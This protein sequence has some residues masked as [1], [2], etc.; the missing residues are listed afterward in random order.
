MSVTTMIGLRYYRARSTNGYI[1]LVTMVSF[2]GL[3]LGVMALVVVVSVMNGFDRELKQRILGAVPHVTVSEISTRELE[4]ELTGFSVREITPFQESQLLILTGSGSH[5][6]TVYG[7]NP[8]TEKDASILG[9]SMVIGE[10]KDLQGPAL[11]LILGQSIARRFGL[12]IGQNISLVVPVVSSRG[13]TVKPRLFRA[14]LA[15]TFAMGSELDHRLGVMHLPDLHRIAGQHSVMR[16]TLDDIFL[17]PRVEEQLRGSGYPV[18]SWTESFGDFFR[19]VRMEKIMMF[20]LLSFVVTIASFSIVS[21]VTMMV[22]S[23]K[24]DIAVL[25]TMGLSEWG[26]FRIFLVQGVGIGVAGVFTGLLLGVPLAFN[27]PVI[28]SFIDSVVGFSIV[29]GTYFSEI[30]SDVRLSDIVVIAI[31]TF[32]ISFVATLYPSYRA[33]KLHPAQILRYE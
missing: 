33:T 28:M 32:T 18:T 13:G 3:V 17:A 21:G 24:R 2:V 23:K 30:P 7:I 8:E 10:L 29:E 12:G 19:T 5:L 20:V 27:I 9:Q 15:G 26:V 6:I 4:A 14:R 1:S 31:V 25:R 22:T 11:E 16:I